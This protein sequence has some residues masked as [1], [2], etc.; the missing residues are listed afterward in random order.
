MD[1][2]PS[3]P[4]MNLPLL[5]VFIVPPDERKIS[6]MKSMKRKIEN[7][8]ASLLKWRHLFLED[9]IQRNMKEAVKPV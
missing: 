7:T 5:Q 6:V 2:P 8:D 4:I 3:V 1:A 9:V